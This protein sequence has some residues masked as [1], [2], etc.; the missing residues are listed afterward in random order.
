MQSESLTATMTKVLLNSVR[1]NPLNSLLYSYNFSTRSPPSRKMISTKLHKKWELEQTTYSQILAL[2][3]KT[4]AKLQR[5]SISPICLILRKPL[6]SVST[7]KSLKNSVEKQL[8]SSRS[9]PYNSRCLVC[10]NQY[11]ETTFK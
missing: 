9:K 1:T 10:Q 7:V 3:K 4:Q 8:N 2:Q 5:R 6:M 11:T